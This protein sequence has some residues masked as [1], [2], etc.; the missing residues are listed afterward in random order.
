MRLIF[1]FAALVL[2]A[3]LSWA[4]DYCPGQRMHMTW[5]TVSGDATDGFQITLSDVNANVSGD[6]NN[7]PDGE[8]LKAIDVMDAGASPI[9]QLFF[10]F[11]RKT[12]NAPVIEVTIEQLEANS[13]TVVHTYL[14]HAMIDMNEVEYYP[15]IGHLLVNEIYFEKAANCQ[16]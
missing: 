4:H 3:N 7:E 10:F 16:E 13:D 6:Y 9:E 14:D 15:E 11:S 8:Y 5:H 1:V 12:E 2:G